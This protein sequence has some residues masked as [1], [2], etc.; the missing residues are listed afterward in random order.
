MFFGLSLAGNVARGLQLIAAAA[1]RVW[2]LISWT[3]SKE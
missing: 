1:L 3:F 2:W